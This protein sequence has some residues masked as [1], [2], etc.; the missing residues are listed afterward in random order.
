MASEKIEWDGVT[1]VQERLSVL[2]DL[3]DDQEIWTS[4]WCVHFECT[5]FWSN[6]LADATCTPYL[7]RT[8]CQGRTAPPLSCLLNPRR[9]QRMTK[10]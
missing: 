1:H 5:P 7:A 9:Q 3:L 8:G 2:E 6:I 4:S 10:S